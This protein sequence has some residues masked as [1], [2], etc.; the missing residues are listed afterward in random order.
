MNASNPTFATVV[1]D[2]IAEKRATG[3]RFA[4]EAQVLRRIVELRN[5]IGGEDPCLSAELAQPLDQKNPVGNRDQQKRTDL[6]P[7]WAVAVHGSYGL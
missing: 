2:Y 4:K 5:Q 6:G 7:S 3:Y 1:A